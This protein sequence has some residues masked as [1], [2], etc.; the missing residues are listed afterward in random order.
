MS[1]GFGVGYRDG[2]HV[3]AAVVAA[4]EY[5]LPIEDVFIAVADGLGLDVGQVRPGLRLGQ[6]LPCADAAR[7]DGRQEGLLLLLGTPDEDGIAAEASTGIVVGR[8]RQAEGVDLL[9][10]DHGAIHLESA[11]AVLGGRGGPE[12]PLVAQLAAQLAAEL[13]LLPG[14]VRR[15]GGVLDTARDV[16]IQPGV[17]LAAEFFLLRGVTRFK[18]HG[19]SGFSRCR[20]GVS[21][22]PRECI[23]SL[24]KRFRRVCHWESGYGVLL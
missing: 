3:V 24:R 9:L 23:D 20:S 11:A 22:H 14:Q 8:E 18:I 4:D 12:P 6:Q 17:D 21:V 10:D 15:V 5:L 19:A 7:E 1:L 16:L 2:P 13:I